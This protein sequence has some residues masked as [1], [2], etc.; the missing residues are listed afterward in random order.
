M[1]PTQVTAEVKSKL[2]R[3]TDHFKDEL[4]KLRTGRAHPSMLDG[5]TVDAYGQPMPLKAVASIL[6]PEPQS[7]QITP[8]DVDNLQAI[9]NAIRDDKSLGLSPTDDGRVVRIVL[10]P[11][12]SENRQAMVK[13]L[14]QK[15]E[16]CLVAA[17]QARHEALRKG[18]QA[19]KAK[20][21]GKDERLHFE[22]QIDEL[23]AKHKENI[24][25][26]TKTKEQ[27]ILTV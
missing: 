12:T 19:E 9:A 16:D 7:L 11:M 23:V 24:E 26:M 20:Q 2:D 14:H 21:I 5:V 6:A 25:A 17:R 10:P 15:S 18:E 8:F 13:V 27:E 3:A 22:K 4:S 1:N